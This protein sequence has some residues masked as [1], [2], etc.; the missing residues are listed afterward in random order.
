M[1]V[2]WGMR[3][4]W[5]CL[6]HFVGY[7]MDCLYCL[8]TSMVIVVIKLKLHAFSISRLGCQFNVSTVLPSKD[9]FTLYV[10]FPFRRGTEPFSKIVSCVIKRRCSHWQE[11][12][13]HDLVTFRRRCW[14][15]MSDV[16][17]RVRTCLY[18]LDCDN[19]NTLT[20]PALHFDCL[21]ATSAACFCLQKLIKN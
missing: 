18:L 16:T 2:G 17:E 9:R 1:L 11:R 8:G 3:S 15:R 10:T 19:V 14:A 13:R 21:L 7:E 5:K 4:V 20:S 6:L 12:L